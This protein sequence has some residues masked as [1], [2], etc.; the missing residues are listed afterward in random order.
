[1][2]TDNQMLARYVWEQSNGTVTTSYYGQLATLG[3]IGV[4]ALNLFR[5]SKNSHRAKRYRGGIRGQGSYASMAYSRKQWSMTNLCNT[6]LEHA[7]SLSITWG[8]KKDPAQE[9]HCWVL[10]ADLPQG[11]VSFHTEQR[12]KGPDYLGDW[13]GQKLSTE[14]ILEFC[15]SVYLRQEAGGALS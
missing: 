12:G 4:V 3:P 6:L 11:Q 10:Y 15:D 7:K 5:A 9:F 1:M 13:D 8:W 2:S 14:R